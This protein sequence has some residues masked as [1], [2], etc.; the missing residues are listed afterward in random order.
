MAKSYKLSWAAELGAFALSGETLGG[1]LE[2]LAREF[3]RAR[4]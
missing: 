3:L 2:R 1:L 4:N